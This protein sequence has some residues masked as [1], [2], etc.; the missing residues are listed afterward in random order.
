MPGLHEQVRVLAVRNHPPTR[1]KNF[2]D[3]VGAKEDI[4][5][6]AGNAIDGRSQGVLWNEF[7]GDMAG[8]DIDRDGLTLRSR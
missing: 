8:R 4:R 5:R 2:L 6:I 7:V 3:L 1:G